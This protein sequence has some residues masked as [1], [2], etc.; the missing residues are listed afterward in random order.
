MKKHTETVAT[1]TGLAGVPEIARLKPKD[2][3]C[4]VCAR[5]SICDMCLVTRGESPPLPKEDTKILRTQDILLAYNPCYVV[6][7]A[8]EKKKNPYLQLGSTMEKKIEKPTVAQLPMPQYVTKPKETRAVRDNEAINVLMTPK[9]RTQA[10]GVLTSNEHL[11]YLRVMRL[12]CD[13]LG[14]WVLRSLL[15]CFMNRMFYEHESIYMEVILYRN[16]SL[17]KNELEC[18]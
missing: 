9:K 18:S 14:F 13:W 3:L 17:W 11:T 6:T 5:E 16:I 4:S 8:S 15:I 1:Q 10:Q 7:T 2:I 12:L